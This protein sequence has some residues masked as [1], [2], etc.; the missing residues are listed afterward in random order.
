M[1]AA[2]P[3]LWASTIGGGT[4]RS[5]RDV[6]GTIE[7]YRRMPLVEWT[8]GKGRVHLNPPAGKTV[9]L[10]GGAA[11][12]WAVLDRPR[13]VEEIMAEMVELEPT[14]EAEV[15][16]SILTDLVAQMLVARETLEKDVAV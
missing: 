8:V 6:A 12:V 10:I 3:Q 15:V 13:T 9:D 2:S 4:A 1:R 14:L 11:M 5:F 7:T 16:R